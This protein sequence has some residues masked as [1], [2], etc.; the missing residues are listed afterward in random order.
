[1]RLLAQG[2]IGIACLASATPAL[3]QAGAA[4]DYD[5]PSQSLA[6]A[7]TAIA[8]VSGDNVMVASALVEGRRSPPLKG[9]FQTADALARVLSGT[10]LHAERVG[11]GFVV[12]GPAV[13]AHAD[14]AADADAPDVVVT[15]SRIRGGV[16]ASPVIVRTAEAMRDEGQATLADVI[17]T[18]PQNFGGGQNPG[19]GS[20]VPAASAVNV[21]GG[22]SINLRGLG[23]DATLTLLNGRRLAY[24]SSRQSIDVSAIPANALDRIEVVADGASAIYG[25]DAIAGVANIILRRDAQGLTTSARLGAS[26][27]GGNFEQIYG[28][29]TGGRWA[30]GGVILAYEFGRNTA[31]R[32]SDRSYARDRVPGLD[33]FPSLKR[34]SAVLSGHQAL[35]PDVEISFDFLYNHRDSFSQFP[36]TSGGTAAARRAEQPSQSTTRAIAP[37]LRWSPGAWRFEIAGSAGRDQVRYATNQFT[38][39]QLTSRSFGCYCNDAQTVELSGNG[40]V[41]ALPGGPAR[42]ALGIGYRNNRLVSLRGDNVSQNVDENQDSRYVYGEA[43]LPLVGPAQAIPGLHSLVASAALRHEDYPGIDAVTTPKLGLIYAPIADIELKAS[44]GRSFRAPTLFQRFQPLVIAVLPAAAFGATGVP[45]SAGAFFLSGGRDDLRPE[46]AQSWSTTMAVTPRFI[47][48]L[49]AEIS[50]FETRYTD[51]IVSPVTFVARALADPSYAAQIVRAPTPA[52]LGA[53][54]A[55]AAQ[56]VNSTGRPYDPANIVAV[57]DNANLNAGRQTVR[58]VDALMSYQR[59]VGAGRLHASMSLGY[60]ESD[61]QLTPTQPVVELA[62]AIF[63]PPSLRGRAT[64]GW[65]QGGLRVT[66]A[67]SHVGG[68]EDRRVSPAVDID[69]LT[70]LDL[71]IRYRIGDRSIWWRGLDLVLTAQNILNAKPDPIATTLPYDTPYDSTNYSPFGRFLAFSV[72]KSW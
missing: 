71:T 50:Y 1:M 18:I 9:R 58:G 4:R 61:Q 41:F 31:I 67:A 52:A 12:R 20:N 45:A 6:S 72:T 43:S 25:S 38:G 26:T 53:L 28:A 8:R 64:L 60:I 46:R 51:R 15:G 70:Q 23:S 32:S 14:V 27:D 66:A 37:S 19:I 13:P 65:H 3:A 55:A 34:H 48:G 30:G 36:L 59:E 47:D 22:A 21:G 2:F 29:S 35:A 62:G 39:S 10:G 11:T 57:I 17:R 5:L 42:I 44:W 40:P 56:F 24:N 49:R 69:G 63:N 68:V 54:R 16:V 7:L 33:L